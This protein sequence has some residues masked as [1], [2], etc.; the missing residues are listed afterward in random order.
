MARRDEGVVKLSRHPIHDNLPFARSHLGEIV[1]RLR[2][3]HS[4]GP[5]PP[6]SFRG[7]VRDLA[8][9]RLR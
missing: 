3:Q 1:G 6:L 9:C 7:E 8:A 2:P 4:V 5:Q